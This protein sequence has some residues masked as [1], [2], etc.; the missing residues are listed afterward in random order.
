M[1]VKVMKP[2][3]S[4]F[5][6]VDY[7]D[8]KIDKGK[9]ELMLMNNFP[10]FINK[11]S[12][13]QKVRDYLKAIS[14][15]R[16]VQKPQFHAVISTKFQEHSKEELTRI[17]EDFMEKLGYGKQPYIA[18]FHSDT[19]NNHIHIVSTRVNKQT[20][21]K[22]DD[23]YEKLKAQKALTQVMEKRYG[24]NEDEKLNQLL[25][26]KIGSFQ[27]LKTL[28]N[29]NGYH[30]TENTNDGKS[31]TISKNG[32][33]Q[34]R[35]SADQIVF[36]NKESEKRIRQ[37]RAIF[38]KYKQ[39][40]S[41][42]VFRVD[43][44]RKQEAMLPTEKQKDHWRPEI[45]FESELQKKLRDSFGIDI[46]FHHKDDKMPF[47]YTLIDHKTGTVHKGSEIM[48]M[49]ELFEFTWATMDKRL[50]EQM[51]DYNIPNPETKTVLLEFLKTHYPDD[52]LNDF[53]LF[54]NKKLKNRE[55]FNAIRTDV[56]EYLRN[57]G[58]G[59]V[60]LIKAE[61]EKHYAI[62]TRLHFIGELQSLIGEQQYQKF[63]EPQLKNE[64]MAENNT[65]NELK[66][67]VNEMLFEWMNSS[68]TAKDPAENE[69]KKRRKKR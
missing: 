14:Q 62:H 58:R 23:S 69:L 24:I 45:E 17:S 34:R 10:S 21:K 5:P 6:G 4:G 46:V 31:I 16:K 13:K 54:E 33:V 19:E 53:M 25:N 68:G 57:Q 55:T 28:L 22:I 2:A 26:Y 56:K 37:I 40:Y 52:E 39:L 51:K 29:R 1:I 44:Y 61:D 50:L 15:S 38:S 20:G 59:D 30:L 35:I 41:N 64:K 18:V 66:Q 60:I 63:L 67:V 9:G 49:G 8:K 36:S 12:G 65:G 43:D 47:G 11:D 7:N 48:K 27:Q 3:G 42:K 32:I